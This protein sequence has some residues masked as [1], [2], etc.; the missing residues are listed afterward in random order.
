MIKKILISS[1]VIGAVAYFVVVNRTPNESSNTPADLKAVEIEPLD[2]AAEALESSGDIV[3]NIQSVESVTDTEIVMGIE[4]RKD[5][6]CTVTRRY[7]DMGDGT[8]VEA[9]SCERNEPVTVGAYDIYTNDELAEMT[10]ADAGASEELGKRLAGTK[11]A[12]SRTLMLRAVALSDGRVEPLL[13]LAAQSYSMTSRNGE[14]STESLK[15]AY[16]LNT[17]AAKLGTDAPGA[18]R[19]RRLLE[20][21]G[22]DDRAIDALHLSVVKDLQFIRDVQVQVI[23][24]T[25]VE[26]V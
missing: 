11:P 10:Y 12:A 4:V 17:V 21:A 25:T 20:D 14:A 26:G 13:W 23:G 19:L 3:A 18:K 5:R 6:N 2:S 1:I 7:V 16:I 24:T 22:L 15:Q 8:V 9:F